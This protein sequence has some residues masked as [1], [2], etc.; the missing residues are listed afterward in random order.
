MCGILGSV[1]IGIT[2]GLLDT[3]RHRGPDSQAIWN[4]RRGDDSI[5]MAHTRLAIVDLS[6]AGRQPMVSEDGRYVLVFN[7][8]I[9]NH[10]A[11]KESLRFRDF[12]GHSDTETL[13]HLLIEQGTDAIGKLNGIF[14]FAFYDR[15]AGTILLARD[16]Y[17]VK[18]VYYYRDG[19]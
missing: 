8:E 5:C 16:R 3:I 10:A 12:R 4:A 1:N 2:E 19:R 13:L 9:Y 11:L 14:A 6:E 17:G 18:P 15:E 7:G